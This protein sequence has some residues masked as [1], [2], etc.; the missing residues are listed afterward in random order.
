MHNTLNA[1]YIKYYYKLL[2]INSL[3]LTLNRPMSNTSVLRK[4]M[5]TVVLVKKHRRNK[6]GRNYVSQKNVFF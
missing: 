5:E 1:K 4:W 6:R 2:N 3:Q